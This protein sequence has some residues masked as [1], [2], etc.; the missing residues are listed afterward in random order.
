MLFSSFV[1]LLLDINL[2]ILQSL[3]HA[4]VLGMEGKRLQGV[5]TI[6]F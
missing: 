4:I 5:T 2:T 6:F 3:P 1:P